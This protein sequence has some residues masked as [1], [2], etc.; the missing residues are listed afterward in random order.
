MEADG[1]SVAL[2]NKDGRITRGA[3]FGWKSSIS[4]S[5]AL[6]HGNAG[7]EALR[8]ADD[9]VEVP[10]CFEA[11]RSEESMARISWWSFNHALGWWATLKN[12]FVMGIAMASWAGR[13]TFN[14]CCRMSV[15]SFVAFT[16]SYANVYC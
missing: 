3:A 13:K 7:T 1:D 10:K 8:F 14:N 9:T 4:E 15:L 16:S 5:H 11:R 6:I 2:F 12:V